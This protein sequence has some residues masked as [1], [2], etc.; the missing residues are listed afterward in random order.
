M[1]FTSGNREAFETFNKFILI[2]GKNILWD[3][4]MAEGGYD[5]Y[6][7]ATGNEY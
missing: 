1:D 6:K 2:D 3:D 5:A 4:W 7:E